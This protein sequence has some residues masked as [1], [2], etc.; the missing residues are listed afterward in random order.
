MP[1]GNP[2]CTLPSLGFPPLPG[3]PPAAEIPA[4]AAVSFQSLC[5]LCTRLGLVQP[6]SGEVNLF[7]RVLPSVPGQ[8]SQ[9]ARIGDVTGVALLDLRSPAQVAAVGPPG[10]VLRILRARPTMHRSSMHIGVPKLGAIERARE[11]IQLAVNEEVL[12]SDRVFQRM[13]R[14]NDWHEKEKRGEKGEMEKKENEQKEKAKEEKEEKGATE[15]KQ[16]GRTTRL[17]E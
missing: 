1:R 3:L 17:R 14:G 10:T 12:L 5:L 6:N 8:P 13:I 15:R 9:T 7:V 11:G 16:R 2:H 4:A